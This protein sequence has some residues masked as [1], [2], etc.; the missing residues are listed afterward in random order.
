[1]PEWESVQVPRGAFI[2]FGTEKGQFVEGKV[3]TIDLSGGKDLKGNPVPQLSVELTAPAASVKKNGDR[4]DYEA[5]TAVR[6]TAS[7]GGLKDAIIAARINPTDLIR[8]EL[9]DVVQLRNGNTAK[10]FDLKVARAT[11]PA[12]AYQ[13]PAAPAS[14]PWG[15][16][17]SFAPGGFNQQAQPQASPSFAGFESSAPF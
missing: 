1:M 11:E 6:I 12:P 5:G 3:L 8:I 9:T 2:S 13:A 7:Q 14:D 17:Q 16:Q 10:N 4:T 15:S